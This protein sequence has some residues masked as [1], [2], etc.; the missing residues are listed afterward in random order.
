MTN[1]VADQNAIVHKNYHNGLPSLDIDTRILSYTS[2]G[3]L[4]IGMDAASTGYSFSMRPC[5]E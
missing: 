3:E 5:K 4:Y 1:F 2:L